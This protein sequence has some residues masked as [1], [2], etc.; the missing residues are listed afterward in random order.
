LCIEAGYDVEETSVGE[1]EM[2]ED[3]FAVKIEYATTKNERMQM[4]MIEC[5]MTVEVVRS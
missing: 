3:I 4:A 2:S 1:S 5:Y